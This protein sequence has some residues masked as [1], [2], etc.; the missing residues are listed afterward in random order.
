ML[1]QKFCVVLFWMY[2]DGRRGLLRHLKLDSRSSSSQG[3]PWSSRELFAGSAF[4]CSRPTQPYT[5]TFRRCGAPVHQGPPNKPRIDASDHPRQGSRAAGQ[6]LSARVSSALRPAHARL[7]HCAVGAEGGSRRGTVY[8]ISPSAVLQPFQ[9]T[10][11]RTLCAESI[12]ACPPTPRPE[13]SSV[14]LRALR[15]GQLLF[16]NA[17]AVSRGGYLVLLISAVISHQPQTDQTPS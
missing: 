3:M 10:S 4:A 12:P 5:T 16:L 17:H 11:E 13:Y 7:P 15:K 1:F 6:L 2:S 8:Q 14:P 9:G